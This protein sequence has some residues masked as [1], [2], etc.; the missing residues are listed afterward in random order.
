MGPVVVEPG[1]ES[2]RRLLLGYFEGPV[3]A[4]AP[5]IS[6]L[7]V[8]ASEFVAGRHT[9]RLVVTWLYFPVL[10]EKQPA[11]SPDRSPLDFGTCS[12]IEAK[13]RG[14]RASDMDTL[15]GDIVL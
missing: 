13:L 2:V 6:S 4:Q 5:R 1:I 14:I 9:A 10:V 7:V 8:A 15:K 12:L 11:A 3:D